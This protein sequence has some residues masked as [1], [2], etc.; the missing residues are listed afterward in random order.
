MESG[1]VAGM[2]NHWGF[3]KF[4]TI[5]CIIIDRS[6]GDQ[7]VS[8]PAELAGYVNNSEQVLFAYLAEIIVG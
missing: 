3:S 2:L 4:A 7:V 1:V 5:C 6:K 8:T